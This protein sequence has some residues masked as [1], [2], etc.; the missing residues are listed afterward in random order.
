M[1]ANWKGDGRF[2]G[3]ARR[4]KMEE[5]PVNGSATVLVI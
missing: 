5:M 2:I 4:G 3:E 1:L